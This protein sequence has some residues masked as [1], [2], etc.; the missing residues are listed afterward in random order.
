MLKILSLATVGFIVLAMWATNVHSQQQEIDWKT[1]L[2]PE[3]KFTIEY[4]AN[5]FGN[6]VESLG[7]DNV[8]N[9]DL[10]GDDVS[11]YLSIIPLNSTASNT[12]TALSIIENQFKDLIKSDYISSI[13]NITEVKYGGQEAYK[14]ILDAGGGAVYGYATI[15]HG[16]LVLHFYMYNNDRANYQE[17]L[18]DQIVNSTKFFD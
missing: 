15:Q 9:F 6:G 7:T 14:T 5:E 12:N 1:Y 17:K 13:Q 2:N 10:T 18:F 16:N 3:Y 11:I 4:P 8:T